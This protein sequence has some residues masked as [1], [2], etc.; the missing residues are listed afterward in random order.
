MTELDGMLHLVQV[1]AV[2]WQGWAVTEALKF[3]EHG[4]DRRAC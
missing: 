2:E 3:I 1:L 4:G